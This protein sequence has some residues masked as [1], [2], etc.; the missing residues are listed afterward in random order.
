MSAYRE[1]FDDK[2]LLDRVRDNPG[3]AVRW[4]AVLVI[5]VALEFGALMSTIMAGPWSQLINGIA[6]ALPAGAEAVHSFT[7]IFASIG[8]ALA[9]LP[10]L[11]TR[12][13]IPNQGYQHPQNGW[14]GTFLGL[15]PGISWALRTT[16]IYG[17]SAFF[18]YWIARGYFVFREHYRY[19]DWTPTDD[20]VERFRHHRWGLFGLSIVAAFLILAIFAPALGPATK[21]ANLDAPYSNFIKTYDEDM[22]EVREVSVGTAN[23]GS[24]SQ[25]SAQN[26]GPMTYDDFGRFH[27]FGTISNGKDLFV[28]MAH[29]ARISLFIGIIAITISGSIALALSIL[30]AYYKGV[31]DLV[32]VVVSDAFQAMPRLLVLI[33]F[34][35][36]L[37][38]HWIGGIY[39]GA[40]LLALLFG[41]WSWPGLWRVVRGPAF[42][43]AEKEWIDAAESYGQP[44]WDLVKTH[45]A[46]YTATYLFIYMAMSIGG[47]IIATAGLSF[48]GLGITA[49]TPEWGRAVNM[50]QDY[51]V[52]QSWHISILPGIAITL[53]VVAFNALSDGVRDANDPKSEGG[54]AD[55]VSAAGGGA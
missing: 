30:T 31:A 44:T 20:A 8:D 25:G 35:V 50:G 46:P 34:T 42:Q 12:D 18:M 53:V 37:G 5:L 39:N 43:A 1:E 28:F 38:D 52:T 14:Q 22:E 3:P 40:L 2:P 48:L 16:L 9:S 36:V 6:G 17:Y 29:G 41:I 21:E 19:A 26:V 54:G 55:E 51:V 45:I 15:S 7:G 27:P 10:T 33:M 13:V 23:L 24:M 49:P 32:V 4:L 11:L 47:I